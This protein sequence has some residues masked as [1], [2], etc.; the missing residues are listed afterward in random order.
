MKL[1]KPAF[2]FFIGVFTISGCE[3]PQAAKNVLPGQGDDE[4]LPDDKFDLTSGRSPANF[5][6]N[7]TV[8][9]ATSSHPCGQSWCLEM[10]PC[11]RESA[12]IH[13]NSEQYAASFGSFTAVVKVKFSSFTKKD[14]NSLLIFEIGSSM[15]Q[16]M[17]TL[18]NFGGKSIAL[19]PPIAPGD[20]REF[21]QVLDQGQVSYYVDS[22]KV[23]ETDFNFSGESPELRFRIHQLP[24]NLAD[25]S[26]SGGT[27]IEI[28]ELKLASS[29][30]RP[31]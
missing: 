18:V 23:G 12:A 4:T 5:L 11:Q 17:N 10:A 1:L 14:L 13:S 16:I 19:N 30:I 8:V 7:W 22:E 28:K 24:E 20:E 2:L 21:W 6:A 9:N 26:I 15:Y 29:V 27:K 31:D 25:C 3:V